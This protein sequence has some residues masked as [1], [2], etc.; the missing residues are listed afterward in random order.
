[1]PSLQDWSR[2]QNFRGIRFLLNHHPERPELCVAPADTMHSEAFRRGL[3]V[4]PRYNASFD[5][6][7][8]RLRC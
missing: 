3:S 6:H 4:L 8:R 5:L 7:V 2:R 1:L